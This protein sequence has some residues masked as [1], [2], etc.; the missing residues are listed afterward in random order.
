MTVHRTIESNKVKAYTY[1]VKF[2]NLW[3]V[4]LEHI[5]FSS[6]RRLVSLSSLPFLQLIQHKIVKFVLK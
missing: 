6:Q 5:S 2:S 4:R 1:L 3:H